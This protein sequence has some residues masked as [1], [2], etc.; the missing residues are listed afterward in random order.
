M[1]FCHLFPIMK[2]L[3]LFLLILL[4]SNVLAQNIK[5]FYVG[6]SLSDQIPDMVLSLSHADN[7]V[8]F[9]Y[10]YQSIPGAPLRWS[11]Q[12]KDRNDYDP[13]PPYLYPFTNVTHGL[14]SGKIDHLVL[15]ESV[16]RQNNHDWGI[17]ETYV[18]A[19]SFYRYATQFNPNIKVWIYE[20]WHC[21]N[22]GTPT[23]CPYDVNSSP[24][25]QRLTDDLPMW[26][27]VPKF[28][29]DK[30][31]PNKEVCLIPA[32][33]GLARLTD[34]INSGTIPGIN[35][36][37]QLFSDDIHLTDQGKYFVACIHF[38]LLHQKSPIGL[39]HQLKNQWGGNFGAPTPAQARR[40]QEIAWE[41]VLQY[42]K[43][44]LKSTS[45]TLPPSIENW[46]IVPNPALNYI[47]IISEEK[48]FDINIYNSLGT[49]LIQT[50]DK[51]ISIQNWPSGIYFVKI[52]NMTKSFVKL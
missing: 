11:W 50:K 19:D 38:A 35:N 20:V 32:G 48:D 43:S 18:F 45:T 42:E 13:L 31:K 17:R 15:T 44:C 3:G 1:K 39:P 46:Q 14:R 36:I 37:N 23:R 40:F 22:S 33:Q 9:D 49:L 6:H 24:W 12:V 51:H 27:S 29:N 5:A 34:A 30:Y 21:I 10:A 28:L 47:N 8:N 25:R 16:P 2:A 41:T 4:K 26:E 7:S 52:N